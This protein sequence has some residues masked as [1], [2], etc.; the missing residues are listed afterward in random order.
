MP[1][2]FFRTEAGGEPVREWLKGLT[3]ADRKR[4][5]EDVKTVELGW[6]IGMPVCRSL[7]NG[8]HE[9]RTDLSN[10]RTARAVLFRPQETHGI[11]ARVRQKEPNNSGE[12]TPTGA[13]EQAPT[14]EG[15]NMKAKFDHSGS[16]FDGFLEEGG[17]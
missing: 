13:S 10:H 15:R 3:K 5:G 8:L 16:T 4:I 7:S 17:I 9:V 14:R 1:V 2:I 12:R 6:P 11:A